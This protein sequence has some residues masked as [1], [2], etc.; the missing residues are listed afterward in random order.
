[1]SSNDLPD[2]NNNLKCCILTDTLN[3]NNKVVKTTTIAPTKTHTLQC[4]TTSAS[5]ILFT[6]K[7]NTTTGFSQL[8]NPSSSYYGYFY[9][10]SNT[11]SAGVGSITVYG[12]DNNYNEITEVITLTSGNNQTPKQ[13]VNQ[14]RWVNNIM[15]SDRGASTGVEVYC[16]YISGSTQYIVCS[17]TYYA[18]YNAFFMVPSGYIARLTSIDNY[19]GTA[20]NTF[21][22]LKWIKNNTSYRDPN[23][24]IYLPTFPV[25][26]SRIYSNGGGVGNFTEGEIVLFGQVS[27]ASTT[28]NITATF[29][30]YPVANYQ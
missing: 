22:M 5:T 24:A 11:T 27:T 6:N 7:G 10:W 14:Y 30:L 16:A 12:L 3:E 4:L 19:G 29:T 17:Q 18:N 26:A 8:N 13:T 9:L 20:A 25:G 21:S 2:I 1:M 15:S 23:T 28:S